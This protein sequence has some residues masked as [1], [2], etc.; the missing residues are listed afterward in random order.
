MSGIYWVGGITSLALF[1]YLLVAL[2]KP[3][4]FLIKNGGSMFLII[5]FIVGISLAGIGIGLWLQNKLDASHQNVEVPT[6]FD[7]KSGELR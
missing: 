7:P 4:I 5:I 3:E 1:I 2:L 6:P